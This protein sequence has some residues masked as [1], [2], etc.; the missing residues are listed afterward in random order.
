MNNDIKLHKD[1]L[2][3]DLDLGNSV[4]VD[5]EFLGLNVKRDALCVIQVSSGNSDAHIIQLNRK[6]YNA[7]NLIKLLSNNKVEKI[8][9][10]ARADM[11]FIKHYLKINVENVQCT[12]LQSRL[13]R[14][15][16]DRHGLKDLIKEII[17]VDISKQQ[18]S[19]D[20]GGE[21]TPAQLKYCANDVIYLHKINKVLNK[22]LVRE[23][24]IDLYNNCLKFL[25]TR[26]DLDLA[27]F[28]DDIWSH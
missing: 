18:Q 8:F 2:P 3:E 1:D 20:F 17:G 27:L 19:S 23:N 7:P 28:K 22:I 26:V 25:Q 9:H 4:A 15:F 11:T 21:L 10:Y 13:A 5:G 16:S 24:R 12:K 14:T 6:T